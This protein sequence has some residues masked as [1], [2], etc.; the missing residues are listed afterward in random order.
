MDL[1]V[2]VLVFDLCLRRTVLP[3][4]LESPRYDIDRIVG[5][6]YMALEGI[7]SVPIDVVP[8]HHLSQSTVPS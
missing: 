7:F 3:S 1:S 6:M 4:S 2:I 5:Q 8:L